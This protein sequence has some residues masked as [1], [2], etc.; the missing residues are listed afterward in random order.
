[1]E[2]FLKAEV[3][4]DAV[5]EALEVNG[6]GRDVEPATAAAVPSVIV[7]P[8]RTMH[9]TWFGKEKGEEVWLVIENQQCIFIFIFLI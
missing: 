9:S 8:R 3:L 5:L 2:G 4:M 7:I 1:M 6:H